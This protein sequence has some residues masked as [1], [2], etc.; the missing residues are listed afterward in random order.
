[1]LGREQV[2]GGSAW[3]LLLFSLFVFGLIGVGYLGLRFG[4]KPFLEGQLQSVE[5]NLNELAA[6]VSPAER[7]RL[8]KFYYQIVNLKSVLDR[9]VI[10]SR[11]LPF[12]ERA[13]HERVRYANLNVNVEQRQVSITLV[14][15]SPEAFVQQIEA[16]RR[17]KEIQRYSLSSITIGERNSINFGVALT[18]AP[19][20]FR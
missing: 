6:L 9:H 19:E 14:A 8:T 12:F 13:T 17:L 5:K 2:G 20:L 15:E 10:T 18:L 3:R 16:F 4:Y 11:I 1:M 7:E